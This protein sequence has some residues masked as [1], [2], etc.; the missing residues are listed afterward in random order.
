MSDSL[1]RRA[2]Q[3]PRLLCP[4]LSPW[5]C[6]NSCPLSQWCCPTISSSV[7]SFSFCPQ[8]FRAS[9]SFP[10]SQLFTSGGQSN[11]VSASG[12]SFQW[13]FRVNFVDNWLVWFSCCPRD[14]QES[15]PVPQFKSIIPSVLSLL[16][17]PALT[18]LHDYWK[19]HTFDYMDLLDKMMSL[20]FNMLSR[21]IIVFLPRSKCLLIL[22]LWSP[23]T[24]ILEP[25]K[26]K[27][28]TVSTVSPSVS[29]FSMKCWDWMPWS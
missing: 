11:D 28:V 4:L 19:N 2:L 16:Y 24:V 18:S 10:V 25:K 13:I 5:V 29:H 26:I 17:V 21:F 15:S 12:S 14:S 3:H 6:S 23:S 20:L 1:W 7:I 9:G 27:S 22:W 8:S